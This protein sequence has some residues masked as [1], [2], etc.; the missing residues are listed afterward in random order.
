MFSLLEVRN[1]A[2]FHC[3]PEVLLE[4]GD[5]TDDLVTVVVTSS[6][7]GSVRGICIRNGSGSGNNNTIV[8]LQRAA[9]GPK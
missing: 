9:S 6:K 1:F 3:F 7:S 8:N 5:T 4:P 2:M